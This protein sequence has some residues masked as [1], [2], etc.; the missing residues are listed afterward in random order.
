MKEKLNFD[1]DRIVE[2][3]HENSEGLSNWGI[4]GSC[5]HEQEGCEPDARNYECDSCGKNTVFGAEEA[6]FMV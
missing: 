5:G 2:L 1:I 4:C 6:L 3:V